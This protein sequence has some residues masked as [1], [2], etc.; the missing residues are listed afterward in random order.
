MT[1]EMPIRRRVAL[2]L[3]ECDELAE[4][5]AGEP[6]VTEIELRVRLSPAGAG[7]VR[8]VLLYTSECHALVRSEDRSVTLTPAE[9]DAALSILRGRLT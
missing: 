3:R 8:A 9:T 2:L 7:G 6:Y 5:D 1:S 4:D